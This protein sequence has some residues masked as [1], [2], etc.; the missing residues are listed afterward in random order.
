MAMQTVV[1]TWTMVTGSDPFHQMHSSVVLF[2][3]YCFFVLT[4][5]SEGEERRE[6]E[7]RRRERRRSSTRRRRRRSKVSC[8]HSPKTRCS[9]L[10]FLPKKFQSFFCSFSSLSQLCYTFTSFLP[11]VCICVCVCVC[12][13]FSLSLSLFQLVWVR[14]SWLMQESILSLSPV[15][16]PTQ[17]PLV[18]VRRAK[19]DTN[20]HTHTER[21]E[22]KKKKKKAKWVQLH[23]GGQ[24][25]LK[26]VTIL[27]T[28]SSINYTFI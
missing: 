15:N 20:S 23:A 24:E 2:S 9:S 5:S 16:L 22:Q 27:S 19:I 28:L 8:Y 11:R 4:E 10:W 1:S 14:S 26:S 3:L 18:D 6:R 13:Y 12:M 17:G 21:E 7:A 25:N